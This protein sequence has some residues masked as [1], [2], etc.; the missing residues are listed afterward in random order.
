MSATPAT[1]PRS[2]VAG[3]VSRPVWDEDVSW[4]SQAA[5]RGADANLFFPPHHQEKKDERDVR[6]SQAKAVCGR[7]PVREACLAFAL[8]TRE[9]HGIWGG[10]NE[11]ERRRALQR[12]AG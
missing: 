9:P 4:Q 12:Q 1:N 7:C 6:E 10:L 3:A 8:E 2:S 5:C 11:L